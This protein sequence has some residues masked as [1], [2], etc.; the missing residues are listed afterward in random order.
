M[1]AMASQITSLTIVYSTIY[2][3]TDHGKYQSSA[4]MAFVRG[5][6]RWPVNSPHK[7]P[8][9]RKMF[10]FKDVIMDTCVHAIPDSIVL[11]SR[12]WVN[13]GQTLIAVWNAV[14]MG[15]INPGIYCTFP[16]QISGSS[17][18]CYLPY[19]PLSYQGSVDITEYGDPC[20]PWIREE[21]AYN[22]SLFPD[23]SIEDARAFCRN[24]DSDEKPW[25]WTTDYNWDY[26]DIVQCPIPGNPTDTLRNNDAMITSSLRQNDVDDVV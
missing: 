3:G 2:S 22:S 18:G 16:I 6:H 8:V 19:D 14:I 20:L 24:P 10:P 9:T 11:S 17:P 13:V 7:W 25:C 23:G 1:S 21:H 12:R 5:I 26:C 4:S 15:C